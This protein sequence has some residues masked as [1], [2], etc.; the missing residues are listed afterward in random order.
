LE[1][2]FG[3]TPIRL[4]LLNLVMFMCRLF[5]CLSCYA[6]NSFAQ[7]VAWIDGAF[8]QKDSFFNRSGINHAI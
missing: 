8:K 5:V 4:E 6:L 7:D 2:E 3:L 1:Y